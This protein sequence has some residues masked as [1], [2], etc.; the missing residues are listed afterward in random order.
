MARLASRAYA[1]AQVC[2]CPACLPCLLHMQAL[3][4]A[5]SSTPLLCHSAAVGVKH[6]MPTPAQTT[7]LQQ[8]LPTQII[9]TTWPPTS[10]CRR[11]EGA[12]FCAPP[13]GAGPAA[14]GGDGDGGPQV[15][16]HRRPGGAGRGGGRQVGAG[17]TPVVRCAACVKLRGNGRTCDR[18]R[19]ARTL[20]PCCPWV[21]WAQAASQQKLAPLAPAKAAPSHH[22]AAGGERAAQGGG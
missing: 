11:G 6:L 19:R 12:D 1:L 15:C 4:L 22:P 7:P 3:I 9:Q 14:G 8:P 13:G 21:H 16:A 2:L 17:E 18:L 10:L 5:Q 20:W